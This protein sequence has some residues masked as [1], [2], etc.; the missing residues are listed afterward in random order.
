[1]QLRGSLMLKFYAGFAF[2]SCKTQVLKAGSVLGSSVSIYP[3]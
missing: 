2:E 1:M 3:L